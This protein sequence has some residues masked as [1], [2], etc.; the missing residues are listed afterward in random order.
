VDESIEE[1]RRLTTLVKQ[2]NHQLALQQIET[3]AAFVNGDLDGAA[4]LAE[5]VYR[6]SVRS[7]TPSWAM[8]TYAALLFPIRDAQGRVGEL[9]PEVKALVELAPS[10]ITWHA[11]AAGVA[12]AS[13]DAD[14]MAAELDHLG[15]QGY[16]LV[17]DTTWTA[18]M[19][20]LCRP[21]WAMDDRDAARTLYDRLAPYAGSMTWNGLS[22]HG[23]V[24]AGLACLAATIG[25][26]ALIDH[27]R[28]EASRLVERLG[29]PHLLWPELH[30]LAE[31][32]RAQLGPDL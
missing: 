3:V 11:I 22:T 27:H 13:G 24:D 7:H 1:L 17:P 21:V 15:G 30:R 25:D 9:G 5:E 23:P 16:A 4:R 20:I 8:S 12:Y 28:R 14:A 6:A 18:L 32:R 10:F 2:R 31:V 26:R 29:A 19:T